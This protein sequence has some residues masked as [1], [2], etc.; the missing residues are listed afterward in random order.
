MVMENK[1]GRLRKAILL[2]SLFFMFVM[3][4]VIAAQVGPKNL[5]VAITIGNT[6]PIVFNSSVTL[7]GTV[8]LVDGQK[9]EFTVNFNVTDADGTGNINNALVGVNITF[10]GVK[11]SNNSGNCEV[12]GDSSL[13]TRAFRCKVVFN[14][15]D[16]S[17][18]IWSINLS[19]TDN[20]GASSSNSSSSLGAGAGFNITLSSLSAFTLSTASIASSANLG[21]NNK[22]LSLVVNNTGNFDF[23]MLNVTPFDL[24]ASL[25]DFFKLE[26]NF[27]VN[28]TQSAGG[29]GDAIS[30]ATPRNFTASDKQVSATLPHKIS[31]ESDLFGNRTLYIYIDVPTNKG[32]STG[33]VYNASRPWELFA[34]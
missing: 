24:N 23:S 34:S 6:A 5:W 11:R 16:N 28:A 2:F 8:T 27:T 20:T 1:K 12:V 22:E 29:Y 14:Y 10:N 33:V 21:E 17:S 25:T 32:L 26:G 3:G 9:T 15:Y 13:T 18:S 7:N 19:A 31:S 4:S 30:N